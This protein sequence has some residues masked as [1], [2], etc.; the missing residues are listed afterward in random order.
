MNGAVVVTVAG[1]I[2]PIR[3]SAAPDAFSQRGEDDEAAYT[4]GDERDHSEKCNAARD[5]Y[6][7]RAVM[8][9]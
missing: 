5:G 2:Q 7:R 6:P 3:A 9:Q 8:Q 4:S 1:N